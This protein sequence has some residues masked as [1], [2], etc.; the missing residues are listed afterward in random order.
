MTL[1]EA[2][3]QFEE[4]YTPIEYILT[5]VCPT[6]AEYRAVNVSAEVADDPNTAPALVDAWFAAA[7]ALRNTAET[8]SGKKAAAIYYHPRP[9]V[10]FDPG[11]STLSILSAMAFGDIVADA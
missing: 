6:G 1:S 4:G 10:R 7:I 9:S 2:V 3:E 8:T 5:D 11:T